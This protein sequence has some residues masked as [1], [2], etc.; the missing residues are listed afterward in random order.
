M[1]T[2][3]RRC[4]LPRIELID[5]P[6]F[7]PDDPYHWQFDNL[8]LKNLMRRQNLI[9]MALDDLI[10]QTRDAIGSQG[11]LANRLNQSINDDGTL[12]PEAIDAAMHSM[13][14]HTDD[15]FG[16]QDEY[17]DWETTR[18]S[19][20]IKMMKSEADKI[21]GVASGATN[22][23]VEVQRDEDGLDV[24]LFDAG[25][26]KFLPS[27]S[28]TW[29]IQS[30]NKVSAHLGFPIESAHLHYYGQTPVHETISDPDFRHYLINSVASEFV[31]DS[32]RVYVN[33]VRL[34]NSQSI[35]VPGA[36][37]DDPW[38]LLTYTADA[39]TGTF[40]LS[41][42]ISEEDVIAIDYDIQFIA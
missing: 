2:S 40:A 10:V 25:T 27:S 12:K 32:L 35:Y 24:V 13:G 9:N 42:A 6:L 30:P 36:L 19:P 18:T 17:D 15:F 31:E 11:T 1:E 4:Q 14:A 16:T 37:V 38:T 8:P 23:K 5:V 29:E 33:G 39:D 34:S 3:S 7:N 26:L 28:V 21:A 22:L 20:F 41:A